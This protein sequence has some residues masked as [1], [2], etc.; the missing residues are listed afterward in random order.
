MCVAMLRA[1]AYG[2][3]GS[4]QKCRKGTEGKDKSNRMGSALKTLLSTYVH[5]NNELRYL[6][7]TATIEKLNHP[8]LLTQLRMYTS[9]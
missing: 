5:G 3:G 6:E 2:V 4:D 8:L 7:C 9:C 1:G